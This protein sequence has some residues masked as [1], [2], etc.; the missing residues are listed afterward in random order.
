MMRL[1]KICVQKTK[2]KWAIPKFANQLTMILRVTYDVFVVPFLGE[3]P[4]EKSVEQRDENGII[5]CAL[6]HKIYA[7]SLTSSF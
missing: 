6:N 7:W 5:T 4:S 1:L 2:K 3:G